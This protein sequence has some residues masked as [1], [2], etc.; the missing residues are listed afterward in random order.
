MLDN[1]SIIDLCLTF[2]VVNQ[3]SCSYSDQAE[4]ELLIPKMERWKRS[5]V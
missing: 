5:L 2:D 1:H 3:H 4:V